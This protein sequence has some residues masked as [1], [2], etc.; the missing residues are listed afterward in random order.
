MF[1]KVV[2]MVL[3]F[4]FLASVLIPAGVVFAE[5]PSTEGL[6]LWYKFDETAGTTIVDSSGNGRN[7]ILRN[8]N[9]ASFVSGVVGNALKLNGGTN[10]GYVEIPNG[11]MAGLNNVTISSFINYSAAVT[12]Q[13]FYG[14][15]P[16]NQRYIFVSPNHWSGG[17]A[18]AITTGSYNAEARIN[19]SD[20]LKI[21]EWTHVTLVVSGDTQEIILYINGVEVSRRGDVTIKPSD[22]HDPSKSYGGYIG[23][24]LYSGDPFFGGIVDDFRVYNRALSAAEVAALSNQI[25]AYY[26]EQ[27]KAALTLG[28][29]S[30]VIKDMDLPTKGVNGSII[31]WQS[32]NEAVITNDG[33][34]KRP[35]KDDE[36]ATVTLTA[37]LTLGNATATKQ[38]T[39][40]VPRVEGIYIMAYSKE[41]GTSGSRADYMSFHDDSLHLAYSE[42]GVNWT[43]LN[44]NKGILYYIPEK[45]G[46]IGYNRPEA[47]QFRD[48]FIFQ[49]EDGTYGLVATSVMYDGTFDFPTSGSRRVAEETIHYWESTDLLNWTNQK[50]I[51]V[52]GE[53]ISWPRKPQVKFDAENDNYV[54][55]WSDGEGNV[56]YNTIDKDFNEASGPAPYTGSDYPAKIMKNVDVSNP[57]KN[58]IIGSLFTVSEEE[59]AKIKAQLGTPTIPVGSNIDDLEITVPAGQTPDL[60][61]TAIVYYSD[62]TTEEKAVNWDPIDPDLLSKKGSFKV[63]G[64]FE[65]A[66]NYVNP[67]N[68]NGA[69]P[70]IFKGP[71]GYYYYTSSYMNYDKNGQANAQYDRIIIRRAETIQ[72]LA[73]AEERVVFWRKESGPASY[74]IWAPEIHYVKFPG[75]EQGTWAIYFAGGRVDQPFNLHNYV[76]VCDSQ[77]PM[78]GS[79]SDMIEIENLKGSNFDL[80]ATVFEHNGEWYYA[81]AH[82]IGGNSNISIAKLETISRIGDEQ[83]I[84]AEPEYTWERRRDRVLEGATVIK[85]NGK[86]FMAYAAGSTDS[87]YC[88]GLLWAEDSPETNLLD[89]ASWHKLP[90]PLMIASPENQ[91]FGPGHATF[92]VAEDGETVILSYHARPNE[93]YS[94]VSGYDPL[95][96]ATRYARVAVVYWHEDGTPYFGIPPKDGYLPGAGV[97]VNVTVTETAYVM[98]YT[99][100][101]GSTGSRV[102]YMGF[103]DDSL[104]LAYSTDGVNWTPLN[105]N[106]GILFYKHNTSYNDNNAKQYR[107]PFIFQKQDGTYVLLA[108]TVR[109]NGSISDTTINYWDSTDLVHWSNQRLITVGSSGRYVREPQAKY[110]P[111]N[112]NYII[113][114]KDQNGNVYYNTIDKNFTT[115]S[116]AA[117]YTGTDYPAALPEGVSLE[118]APKNAVVGSILQVTNLEVEKM[119]Y[120]IGTPKIPVSTE[121]INVLTNVDKAP[122]LPSKG[123]VNYSDGTKEE[124]EIIWEEIDPDKY[125]QPGIFTVT[126]RVADAPDYVN[127]INKNGADPNIYK[128]PDGYYYYTSSYMDY[129]RNGQASAQYDRIAIRRAETIQ[130]LAT[131]EERVIF[132]RPQSGPASYHIWAPEIHYVKFKGQEQGTWVIYFAGARSDSIWAL[133]NY[134]LICDSQDPMA[135]NWTG[136]VKVENIVN[137]TFDLDATVFEHNGEWYYVWAH[138]PSG[139]SNINIAKLETLTRVSN[140]QVTIATPEYTWERR[141][142]RVLEGATVIKRNG[143]IYMAYAAG[144]TDSTYCIGLMWAEDSP[145]TNLLDPASWHKLPYPLM[146]SSP[147][148]QQ[149]GPG[150]ATFTIA[151]DGETVILS[152]HAR[153]NERYSGVS[154]YDPLYDATRYARVAVVYWHEDGTPY[155]GIPPKDGYLPGSIVTATVTVTDV[156][157]DFDIE[158]TWTP[159]TLEPNKMF[160]AHVQATNNDN[161]VFEDVMVIVA[162]YDAQDRMI[163][164]TYI[165]KNIPVGATEKMIAGFRLP[166][167]IDGHK[168]KVFVWDGKGIDETN[169]VP[170]S[171][172]IEV[173]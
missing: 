83:P 90:Y 3:V 88:I 163:N 96:D 68:K 148:T 24:S 165:S 12:N 70:Y 66:P 62:G 147:E 38:F 2:S 144:S 94:G 53:R 31:T 54:I 120:H 19:Y 71:D 133:R 15:G 14:F 130:G 82:K 84:I 145:E 33:K 92:T 151:E 8:S 132:W 114:W 64:V 45:G 1:K 138:K 46:N 170:L 141:R 153:P 98:A 37:T 48:P 75:Q 52:R 146:I 108:T 35:A 169:Q 20:G 51:K 43:A 116:A 105:D 61:S 57:P 160:Y 137:E 63:S 11:I 95:Y 77:D 136:P 168:V 6:L 85:K 164:F 93:R 125:S 58:A 25:H 127:P 149:F 162:L 140:E 102:D 60:P 150:H 113:I 129:S 7:G 76:I 21:G 100:Q 143:K 124:K 118:G 18:G 74:H 10:S 89:P 173:Q 49:K 110:D 134:A 121:S 69:D 103:Y 80:D 30:A 106:K 111:E 172:V 27:D 16:D 9:N 104:H 73:T 109:P 23:R 4:V 158:T 41:V 5:E 72:G 44:D 142:D 139:D 47:R 40:V 126:G 156:D 59:L 79:W 86:I 78:T 112:D 36:D 155:F 122:E 166:R 135:G 13:F 101:T 154:G 65:G 99:K 97:T 22:V 123:I 29:T 171:D 115:P 34:V 26:I 87:T 32:D 55:M 167:E 91:Q 67:I 159:E 81:W 50:L 39:V 119:I 42:D 152:Y 28:D 161:T 17:L 157:Y 56:F 128:G 107:H 131:A 117:P